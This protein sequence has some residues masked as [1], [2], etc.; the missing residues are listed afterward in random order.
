[1]TLDSTSSITAPPTRYITTF[2]IDQGLPENPY[3]ATTSEDV[4]DKFSGQTLIH[5]PHRN[6]DIS[7]PDTTWIYNDFGYLFD[8][9][10][11]EKD[12]PYIGNRRADIELHNKLTATEKLRRR[13]DPDHALPVPPP[14]PPELAT[15]EYFYRPPSPE[16]DPETPKE[17]ST[18]EKEDDPT[19]H[20]I[21]H[22]PIEPTMATQTAPPRLAHVLARANMGQPPPP[23]D[24]PAPPPEVPP[25]AP[26]PA[27][28]PAGGGGGGQPPAG[29]GGGGQPPAGGGGGGQP[30]AGGGGGGQPPAGGA[31][32]AAAPAAQNPPTLRLC[33]NPPETF[34]GDRT[35]AD[36]FLSQL[37]RFYLA[38]LGVPEFQSWIRKVV[39]ATTYIQGP[40]VD[41][42]IE[43]II[44]WISQLNPQTDD[45]EDIWDQ[46]LDGFRDQFQDTQKGERARA[47]LET[48]KMKWPFIDQYIQDFE[49]LARDAGYILGDAPTNRLFARGLVESVGKDV[50]KPAPTDDYQVMKRRAID[51]VTSQKAIQQVFQKGG[52]GITSW[53]RFNQQQRQPRPPQD[54]F[55]GYNSSNAP[56]HLNN[57]P[58]PMDLSRTRAPRRDGRYPPPDA[59]HRVVQT[60]EQP[61]Q[62]PQQRRPF[63][64]NCFN[65]GQPGHLARNCRQRRQA[66]VS[67]VAEGQL[68]DWEPA[69]N[70]MPTNDHNKVTSLRSQIQD[71]TPQE[72]EE[73]AKQ[74][75]GTGE[76]EQDFPNA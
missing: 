37:R 32:P 1:M 63:Q 67:Y 16:T 23:P 9:R 44:D 35:K 31:Q 46:F 7:H 33:G 62:Q 11:D 17:D 59:Y 21:R 54:R 10:F 52:G 14:T 66:R 45:I 4:L 76:G 55:Q 74:F 71:L 26:Q 24:P 49:Q 30:P 68:V 48:V 22:S 64:G 42:W 6:F 2:G 39:I 28:P 53:G 25:V 29:G 41:G 57:V 56:R 8:V 40:L 75:G 69:D 5:N 34:D 51:S 19:T 70:Y 50:F 47:G 61:P 27:N 18:S 3:I 58:V 43:G 20:N 38:N 13:N 15:A 65:C 73:L 72:R 36:R 60:Q 12:Q